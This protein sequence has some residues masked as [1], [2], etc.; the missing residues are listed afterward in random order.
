V[1]L[2]VFRAEV[3]TRG[4]WE[5][6]LRRD[7][8]PWAGLAHPQIVPVQRAGWWDGAIYLAMEYVPHGSLADRLAGQPYPVREALKLVE[9]LAEIVRYLHRQ[10]VVH[11]NLK[12]SNV[13]F[14]ADGIPRV[15]DFRP[16]GGLFQGPLPVEGPEAAGLGYLAPEVVREPGAEPRPY[17]DI[18]GLGLILYELLTGRPPFTGATVRETL[19]EVQSQDPVPPSRFSSQVTPQLEVLCLRC[20]RKDPWRRYSRAYDL[21]TRLQYLQDN[22]GRQDG[23]SRQGPRTRPHGQGE[24]FKRQP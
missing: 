10:G 12:P 8:E 5:A 18:Y 4:E 11:G 19:E 9:Q 14:A 1:V 17:T 24:E 23:T 7:A 6:R 16:T 21:I 2:K 20:L 3:C 13:L 22:P 15:S